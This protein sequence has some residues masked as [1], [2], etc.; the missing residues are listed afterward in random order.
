[1]TSK[2]PPLK[3]WTKLKQKSKEK[4][5]YSKGKQSQKKAK[6]IIKVDKQRY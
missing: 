1:V 6:P 2:I 3:E 5:S 4:I